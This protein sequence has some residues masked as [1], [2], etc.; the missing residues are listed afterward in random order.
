M[1][2]L[3][4]AFPK[5]CEEPWEGMTAQGCNRHCASCDKIIHELSEL[6][7]DQAETLLRCDEE[8]CVRAKIGPGGLVQ[9][10][11][12]TSTSHRRMIATVGASFA[13][14]TAACQTVPPEDRPNRFEISGTVPA[15]W[16]P[17]KPIV[18]SSDG[19]TWPV[20]MEWRS[21]SFRVP[22]LFPGIYSITY[23]GGCG[24]E[25][26]VVENIEIREA[27]VDLG[28]LDHGYDCI[29]VGVISPADRASSG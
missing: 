26:L 22:D 17:R 3:R 21:T 28:R 29:I 2:D 23:F 15:I 19:R 10:A 25:Q 4:V 9:L 20:R 8:I 14:A 27:S 13:L 12:G 5:P 1:D 24:E 11:S 6:T 18:Q 16:Q 7:Y